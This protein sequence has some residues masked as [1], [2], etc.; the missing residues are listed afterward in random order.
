MQKTDSYQ[1]V[2]VGAGA[3]GISVASSLLARDKRLQIALIDPSDVHY[4]QPGF[5]MVGGGVFTPE[6][7]RRDMA[8]LI[9]KRTEWIKAAVAAFHPENNRIELNDGRLISYERLIVC[10]G[11]KL[12]WDAIEGLTDTL[13]R[14]GVTSNYRADLAPYTWE[15][16]RNLNKGTAVFTQPPMPIK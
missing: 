2:I 16:V 10:P 7:N 15:L 13:G 4:Y 6:Q 1:I 3:A 14:N 5:T 11:I 8:S 9:P 12:N